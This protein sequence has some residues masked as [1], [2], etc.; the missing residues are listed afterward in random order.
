LSATPLL[1]IDFQISPGGAWTFADATPFPDLPRGGL[2]LLDAI[3]RAL[4]A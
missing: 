3:A 2:A 4:Q 1:G